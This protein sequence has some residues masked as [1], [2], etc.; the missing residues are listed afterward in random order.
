VQL[1]EII[2]DRLTAGFEVTAG[3]AGS[4]RQT[5]LNLYSRTKKYILSGDTLGDDVTYAEGLIFIFFIR[6]IKSR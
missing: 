1:S 4:N 2:G 5:A 3:G 6:V